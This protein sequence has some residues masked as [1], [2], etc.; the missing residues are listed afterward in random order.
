MVCIKV[1]DGPSRSHASLYVP[2]LER[3]AAQHST[4]RYSTTLAVVDGTILLG[5]CSCLLLWSIDDLMTFLFF[6]MFFFLL[7]SYCSQQSH[8]YLTLSQAD[9]QKL[10]HSGHICVHACIKF[11]VPFV[12]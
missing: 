1:T 6:Y 7:A 8:D 10:R 9:W 3:I 11:P 12:P 4:A 5:F 2:R